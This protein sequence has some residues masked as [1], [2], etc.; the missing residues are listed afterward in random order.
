MARA[1]TLHS[2]IAERWSALRPTE[3]RVAEFLR[4]NRDEV[5]LGSASELAEKLRTS[6]ATVIRTTKALGYESLDAMR[7]AVAA[8]GA[9]PVTP[10]SRLSR[11]LADIGD[12]LGA[13]LAATMDIHTQALDKLRRDVAPEQFVRV[14][15]RIIAAGRTFVFGIGPSSTM[16]EYLAMQ[17]GRFGLSARAIT[18]TGL[19]LADDLR[20]LQTGDTLIVFAYSRQYPEV[21]V[22]LDEARRLKLPTTLVTDTF[23][24]QGNHAVADVL[25]V[26]RG[27]AEMMSMHTATLALI[28]AL[29][30][31]VAIRRPKDTINSLR[32]LNE[33]RSRISGEPMDLLTPEVSKAQSR[34]RRR[35]LRDQ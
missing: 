24:V 10:A 27:R 18:R 8:E 34:P 6:D 15:E 9:P 1:I 30:V 20:Q 3:Q 25:L 5:L 26:A 28:E 23:A 33:L 7:R 29:L 21:A 32:R 11:T 4:D 17:L 35:S 2:R 13:A 12:D 22:L 31:G 14:V 19:L 16:A